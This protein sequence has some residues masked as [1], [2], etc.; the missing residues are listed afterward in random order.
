MDST[1]SRQKSFVQS[2]D[3]A[4]TI[5]YA[6]NGNRSLRVSKKGG[7]LGVDINSRQNLNN[8]LIDLQYAPGG[9]HLVYLSDDIVD[10]KFELFAISAPF[11]EDA[12]ELCFPVATGD[13]FAIL[14]L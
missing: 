7:P 1:G 9:Q 11:A 3:D 12:E 13:S 6:A 2:S 8:S 4:K 14:C 10:E 5:V